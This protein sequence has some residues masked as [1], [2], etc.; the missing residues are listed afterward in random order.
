MPAGLLATMLALLA[1]ASA[2]A[3]AVPNGTLTLDVMDARP[4]I[5][6]VI[7]DRLLLRLRSQGD[8]EWEAEV[9]QRPAT[10]FPENLLYH[11]R[12]WHGPYPTQVFAWHV[13]SRRFPDE[14]WLCVRGNPYEVAI[15][16]KDI[17]TEG[18]GADARFVRG[19]IEVEWFRR[20]CKRGFGY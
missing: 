19:T 12:Q 5:S 1:F 7:D 8:H 13:A 3:Q 14:R 18:A 2:R 6:R 9:L 16:L 10:Q 15:R 20:Q 11:S 17:A 4:E